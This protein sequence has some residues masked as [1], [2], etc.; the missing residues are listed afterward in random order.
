VRPI[1]LTLWPVSFLYGAA[2]H[3]RA[4]AYR[5]G[6]LKSRRL[7]AVV[8][9][10][11]NLTAGGTGKTPMVLW[12]AEK[13][14]SEGKSVGILTRGYRGRPISVGDADAEASIAEETKIAN[15]SDEVQMLA[16][17]LGNRVRFGVGANR[18]E[19]GCN[20][21]AQGVNWFVL[22]DGF[23]H[24]HLERNVDIVLIDA[25]SP[26]GGGQLLPAGR[27]REPL[28]AL[29]RADVVVIT[30]TESSPGIETTIRRYSSAP[31]FYAQPH[32]DSI[33]KIEAG[34]L[35][36]PVSPRTAGSLFVFCAI[37]NPNGFIQTLTQSGVT[38][39]GRKFFSDHH[40]FTRADADQILRAAQE[41]GA[42]A[43]ICTEKDLYNLSG[44]FGDDAN[45][46]CATISLKIQHQDDFWHQIISIAGDRTG[47]PASGKIADA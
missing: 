36:D 19:N 41:S 2:N 24:W 43:L 17:R 10:V 21:V 40:R 22:D 33:R 34:R 13:L 11:G 7:D 27:L 29:A 25:M 28:T 8:I 3:L 37:G 16:A 30:R 5:T 26:F 4:R 6:L 20:L 44:S 35:T 18:F 9:S 32:L 14:L 45:L 42:T 46:L 47:P 15:S 38:I 39:A 31:I 12:I 1:D 23:Q